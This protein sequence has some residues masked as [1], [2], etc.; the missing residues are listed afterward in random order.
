MDK[1]TM[2]EAITRTLAP[3]VGATMAE[4]ST[5]AHCEKLGIGADGAPITEGQL[6]ALVGKLG[7]GLAVFIGREKAAGVVEEI[8]R[9]V[10]AGGA[11]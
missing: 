1:A 7:A 9:A 2:L 8:R 5:R 10:G 6:Q 4:A 3:Y 11:P